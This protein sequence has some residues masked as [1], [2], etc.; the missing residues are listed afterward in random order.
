MSTDTRKAERYETMYPGTGCT[1][2]QKEERMERIDF[3]SERSTFRRTSRNRGI[4]VPMLP[5]MTTRL[6]EDRVG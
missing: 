6:P 4:V 5:W 2:A 1:T 3:D